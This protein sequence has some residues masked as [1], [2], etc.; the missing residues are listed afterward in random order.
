MGFGIWD[1]A[2]TRGRKY[3]TVKIMAQIKKAAAITNREIDALD[4]EETARI[5][6]PGS[7]TEPA[8]YG[9]HEHPST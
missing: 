4:P 9:A 8:F 5:L 7:M 3:E 6:D 1:L 2:L